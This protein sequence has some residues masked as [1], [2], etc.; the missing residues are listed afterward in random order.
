[1][2]NTGLC[3]QGFNLVKLFICVISDNES[4]SGRGGT[5]PIIYNFS[6]DCQ[7][8]FTLAN[9]PCSSEDPPVPEVQPVGLVQESFRKEL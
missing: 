8:I 6:N 3:Q 9:G 5:T 1:M 7:S 2:E 4:V